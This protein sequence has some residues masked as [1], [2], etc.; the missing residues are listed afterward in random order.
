[1]VMMREDIF[2][3]KGKGDGYMNCYSCNVRMTITECSKNRYEGKVIGDERAYRV[4]SWCNE[5]VP[6]G[7][8]IER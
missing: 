4:V 1:M 5:C 3:I 6:E 2:V 8:R 7:V